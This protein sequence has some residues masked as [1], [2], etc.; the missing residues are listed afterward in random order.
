MRCVDG[1][2]EPDLVDHVRPQQLALAARG[3][4]LRHEQVGLEAHDHALRDESF[5]AA[6]GA[7]H[8]PV[9]RELARVLDRRAQH[10]PER[11][12]AVGPVGEPGCGEAGQQGLRDRCVEVREEGRLERVVVHLDDPF[13]ELGDRVVEQPAVRV[14]SVDV[15]EAV[16]P[17]GHVGLTSPGSAQGAQ[18]RRRDGVRGRGSASGVRGPGAL[19]HAGSVLQHDP[20][21]Q[22]RDGLLWTVPVS[23]GLWMTP[24][25][26]E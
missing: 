6:S 4:V 18:A 14:R 20:R 19:G 25:P 13:E 21:V 23:R 22:R 17:V 7:Q 16:R 12:R 11:G 26:A 1:A 9:D 5:V 24:E 3:V 10:G 8:E 15:V 2:G